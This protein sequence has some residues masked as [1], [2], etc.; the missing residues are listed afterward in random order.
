MRSTALKPKLGRVLIVPAANRDAVNEILRRNGYG[1][2]NFSIPLT[3]NNAKDLI[4]ET[5]EQA[6]LYGC[7]INGLIQTDLDIFQKLLTNVKIYATTWEIALQTEDVKRDAYKFGVGIVIPQNNRAAIITRLETR[8]PDA[9][10]RF[11]T[12]L[13]SANGNTPVQAVADRWFVGESFKDE[14]KFF[15]NNVPRAEVWIWGGIIEELNTVEYQN[16]D[17][18]NR[19]KAFVRFVD[20]RPTVQDVLTELNLKIIP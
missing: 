5:D 8:Y 15:V 16:P 1:P 10:T 7:N 19:T 3:L 2:N 4:R 13:L 17:R 18:V 9:N 20:V 14:L 11:F 12:T 6:T